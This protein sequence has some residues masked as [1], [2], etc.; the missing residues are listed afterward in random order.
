MVTVRIGILVVGDELTRGMIG[1]RNTAY[2]A[3]AIQEEGWEVSFSTLSGDGGEDIAAA[4]RFLLAR[5]RA[6]VVT[7]GLGPTADDRTTEFLARA[8]GRG[9]YIDERALR[10]IRERFTFLG[11]PWTENNAK[12][13]VFPEGAE[14]VEN[15]VGTAWGYVLEEEEKIVAVLPGVPSEVRRLFPEGILPR[16]RR[17][18]TGSGEGPSKRTVKMFG[19]AEARIDETL[20]GVEFASLGVSLGFYPRFPENHLVLTARHD[21]RSVAEDCL[22]RAVAQVRERLGKYIFAYDEDT[23]EGIVASLL[24]EQGKTLA[25]A[26]SCTGGLVADRLTDV[27][28]SSRYFE[29]GLV[30]YSNSSKEDL[31]GVPP[32]VL[33]FHGAVSEETARLMAEGARARAGTDL[34]LSTTGIAGPSGG[35]DRKPVGTVFVALAG[36]KGTVCRE[37]HFPW[38]RRRVKEISA[39]WALEML[40]RYLAGG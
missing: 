17:R 16:L 9:C 25:V 7:G 27:P 18:L 30:V 8:L 6:V 40:R 5:S 29:R 39:Q 38:G 31:L 15:P 23:L 4:F 1:D 14:P 26:E 34:G 20:S 33:R 13:A 19:I 2:L 36:E 28:G 21:D 3:R 12:Q 22:A 35:T 10:H 37:F 24:T 32:E 11:I